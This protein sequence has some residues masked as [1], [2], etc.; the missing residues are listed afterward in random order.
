MNFILFIILSGVFA[1]DNSDVTPN[2]EGEWA[3]KAFT[4]IKIRKMTHY[5]RKLVCGNFLCDDIKFIIGN[6]V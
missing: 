6:M 5:P 1:S 2:N 4:E 3:F